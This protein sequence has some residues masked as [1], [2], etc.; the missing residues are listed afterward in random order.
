VNLEEIERMAFSLKRFVQETEGLTQFDRSQRLGLNLS[1]FE[2]FF[3]DGIRAAWKMIYRDR[4]L[5]PADETGPLYAVPA[6]LED[7]HVAHAR[8]FANRL[9]MIRTFPEGGVWAELGTFEGEFS[10]TLLDVC[11]PSQLHLLDMDFNLVRK[12][13]YVTESS[14]VKFHQGIS[15]EVL[16]SFPDAYFDFI[17][18]DAGHDLHAVA[19]DVD[20][21]QSKLKPDGT[22][23]FNDYI[24]FS[25]ADMRPFGIV[26]VVNSLCTDE[27][28]EMV[29]FA[30]QSKLY[31]D[32]ALRR[33]TTAMNGEAV[34]TTPA[35]AATG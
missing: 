32:V 35:M 19:R 30:L 20:A 22:L 23:V 3:F 24:I 34:A 11:Q 26:Q 27:D 8:L 33:R 6:T 31:C 15:W 21:A 29:G 28:W 9:S 1:R 14:V 13:G 16:K 2:H 12:R 18:V 7:E 4:A 17:Y 25:Q 5:D 10:R